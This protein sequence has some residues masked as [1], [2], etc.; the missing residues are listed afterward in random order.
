MSS[1]SDK[2]IQQICAYEKQELGQDYEDL[3]PTL[4]HTLTVG[5]LRKALEGVDE[6]LPVALEIMVDRDEQAW[7]SEM[8]FVVKAYPTAGGGPG[9]ER[10]LLN[11]ALPE[12]VEDFL[13]E[14]EGN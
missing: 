2:T 3:T 7:F 4:K 6:K 14:F 11:A 8:G 12:H 10:F 13:G 9:S 1:L 5:D